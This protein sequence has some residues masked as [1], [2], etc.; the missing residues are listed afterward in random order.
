MRNVCLI[1]IFFT[2]IVT[3]FSQIKF[4]NLEN[5]IERNAIYQSSEIH[6]KKTL[7]FKS[8]ILE[9]NNVKKEPITKDKLKS[10]S[11]EYF[12]LWVNK[13]DISSVKV[14]KNEDHL[15]V[16]NLKI[17]DNL[18]IY[19]VNSK[20]DKILLADLF[21][22]N[23]TIQCPGSENQA[24]LTAE[25]DSPPKSI[26]IVT[27]TKNNYV[28]KKGDNILQDAKK[29]IDPK[30]DPEK[31]IQEIYEIY[32]FDINNPFF[33]TV[34]ELK[35]S[36]KN[37]GKQGIMGSNIA[38]TDVTNFATGMARFL[39]DRAKQELNESFFIQMHKQMERI[40][41]LQVYFPES[42]MFLK[43]LDANT[44]SFDLEYL[45]NRFEKDIKLLPNNILEAMNQ[46]DETKYPYFRTA[47][48]YLNNDI[49]GLW[50]NIGLQSVMHSNGNIN[51]KDLL[52]NFVHSKDRKQKNLLL[53]LES[54][55][56]DYD[57]KSQIN[58]INSIKL[59]ELVSNSLLS[60]ETGRYWV[61][62]KE[63][64]ELINDEK[65]FQTYIGL[66]LAKSDFDEYKIA[67]NNNSLKQLIE[68]KYTDGGNVKSDISGL[69]NL[70]LE[71]YQTYQNVED[72]IN[73]LKTIKNDN[74]LA[75]KSYEAFGLVK[76]SVT[77]IQTLISGKEYLGKNDIVINIE[78]LTN[79]IDPS[80][81]VAH[82]LFSKKYNLAIKNFVHILNQ[83]PSVSKFMSDYDLINLIEKVDAENLNKLNGQK[84]ITTFLQQKDLRQ[85]LINSG[86]LKEKDIDDLIKNGNIDKTNLLNL[87]KSKEKEINTFLKE[88]KEV[89]VYFENQGKDYNKFLSKFTTYGTLIA[90]VSAAQNSDE[91]KAA[92]QAAVLPV[93]SSRIKRYSDFS[94]MA[95]AYVGGFYG[96]AYYKVEG[97]KKSIATFGIT[98]PIGVT[99]A[100]GKM[101]FLGE[102]NALSLNLQLIDLGSLVNFYYQKGDGAQL[103]PDTK[104]QL[105]DILA[106]GASLSY[107]LF[108]SPF[109]IFAG[110]Q[111]VPN[112]SRMEAIST[113]TELKPLTWRWH[114]GI[115]IDIPLLSLWV[116]N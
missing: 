35:S 12:G 30:G 100:W 94:V 1:T 87:V 101:K 7:D 56:K 16:K 32:R 58:L 96:Q 70:I 51:P 38:K 110:A 19:F 18:K 26:T 5:K 14:P 50:L 54:K 40:P 24:S 89:K 93:G 111:Y 116:K 80:V 59:A 61:S 90:N 92:I 73:E 97:E 64:N 84:L 109:S 85:S 106:P 62:S 43:R 33:K 42:Y 113:N 98:A 82:N 3:A 74:E 4:E 91:V 29:L 13:E 47:N 25:A 77:K 72:Q 107:S 21:L 31:A 17:C 20:D 36:I 78:V 10:Q 83:V 27:P 79:Y 114:A 2:N 102:N 81:E 67:F 15:L 22:N 86:T 57:D 6:I 104:V 55:L 44:M 76:T 108:N 105:G 71:I 46:A 11:N 66:L 103:P 95:N 65:L 34:K 75:D 23:E 99:V 48:H 49:N 41:E 45:K 69:K 9:I 28:F 53:N 39:A 68:S 63:I 115:A 112:L 8:I 37:N 88:N 60:P 52:Y